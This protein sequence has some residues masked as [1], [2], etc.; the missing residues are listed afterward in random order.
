MQSGATSLLSLYNGSVYSALQDTFPEF[1]WQ[2]WKFG[3][4][5]KSYW[6]ALGVKF[7]ANDPI[8]IDTVR[9]VVADLSN[10]FGVNQLEDWYRVS[11][12]TLSYNLTRLRRLGGLQFVLDKLYPKH[13]WQWLKLRKPS[14]F[15]KETQGRILNIVTKAFPVEGTQSRMLVCKVLNAPPRCES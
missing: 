4:T 8:A 6:N 3:S 11:Q 12:A 15:K 10:Q 9:Q 13:N 1:D 14:N 7:K 5:P 2:R